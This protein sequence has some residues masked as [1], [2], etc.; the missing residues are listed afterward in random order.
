MTSVPL[1]S[2]IIPVLHDAAPLE[3]L[4]SSLERVDEYEVI[5][6]N[7]D[8][9]DGTLGPLRRRFS[10][11]RWVDSQAGRGRQMNA[12]ARV[13]IGRWLCF[14]H[15]DVALDPRWFAEVASLDPTDVVGGAFRFQL[16]ASGRQARL[17]E[18]GV[19]LRLRWFDM[20]YGD[21]GLFVRREIFEKLGGFAELPIM[22]DIEFTRRLRRSGQLSWS[23]VPIAVSA[24]RWE[25]DGWVRRSL[26]NMWLVGLYFVGIPP[27]RLA[28][29]YYR[30]ASQKPQRV[31]AERP[32]SD[33][34]MIHVVMPARDEQEAVGLVLDEIP[35][36]VSRVVVVDNGSSDQTVDIA[37]ARG[38]HVVSEPR[39]GYG[40]ACLAGLHETRDADVVVFLDADRT[41]YPAEMSKLVAPIR[42][43]GAD[44][45]LGV[46]V[47][48]SRTLAARL[49]TRFCVFL[50]NRL[51]GTDYHDL[52]PF[53]AVKRSALDRLAM[54]DLTWGWTVEMQ[55]KAAE[56]GLQ[57][58]EVPVRQRPRIGRSKISG[59]VTG[60]VRAGS[61]MLATIFSLRWTRSRRSYE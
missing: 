1:I 43:T 4:L 46:R 53:R 29:R 56:A 14:L 48:P 51:W 47:D 44:L 32:V 39:R 25:R 42:D 58:V 28:R 31:A 38:A 23:R 7:G 17:I 3:R 30:R 8:S 49:G 5:V 45:V 16:A 60:T 36:A 57:V 37:R 10:W 35:E 6:V 61:R 21:Q 13:A 9:H 34:P 26:L 52:G 20:P 19:A 55:I 40:R 11:L 33:S 2:V 15:A 54:A 41:D 50:I 27:E 59:T 12:G 18:W 24:R 22:E